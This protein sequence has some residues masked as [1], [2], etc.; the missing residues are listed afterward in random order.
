MFDFLFKK[1]FK[2]DKPLTLLD[3]YYMD[4]YDKVCSGPYWISEDGP[5]YLEYYNGADADS[6]KE[7]AGLFDVKVHNFVEYIEN[8]KYDNRIVAAGKIYRDKNEKFI[9]SILADLAKGKEPVKGSKG[10]NVKGLYWYDDKIQMQLEKDFDDNPNHEY[11][12]AIITYIHL[13][14]TPRESYKK[15]KT[16]QKGSQRVM[17]DIEKYLK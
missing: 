6:T 15:R 5:G 7:F 1:R 10:K 11:W 16:K 14:P 12:R 4:V 9:D 13:E 8:D 2:V 3:K 17:D